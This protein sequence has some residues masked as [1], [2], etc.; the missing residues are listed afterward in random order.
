M[1]FESGEDV[2]LVGVGGPGDGAGDREE[3]FLAAGF[4]AGDG[5]GLARGKELAG[6]KGLFGLGDGLLDGTSRLIVDA[7]GN[8]AGDGDVMLVRTELHAVMDLRI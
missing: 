2:F 8:A 1:S 5:H 3:R 4:G 7:R 6:V